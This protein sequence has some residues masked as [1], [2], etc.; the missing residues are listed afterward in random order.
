[1][2]EAITCFH[3]PKAGLFVQRWIITEPNHYCARIS[4][5]FKIVVAVEQGFKHSGGHDRLTCASNSR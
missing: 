1:M 5:E 2:R 3:Q 4:I